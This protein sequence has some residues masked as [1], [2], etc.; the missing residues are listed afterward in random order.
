VAIKVLLPDQVTGPSTD[1]ASRQQRFDREAKAIAALSQPHICAIFDV[2]REDGTAF[3]VM[4]YLEDETLAARL[5][6]GSARSSSSWRAGSQPL[7]SPTPDDGHALPVAETLRIATALADALAAA[8]RAG[9]VHRDLKP[10]NIMLTKS[11]VK[12]LDFGLAKALAADDATAE[13][14]ATMTATTPL[15]GMGTLLGTM[16]YM[17][18]EQVEG[19]EADA[20]SDIFALGAVIYEM[21]T[22]RRA[23]RGASQAS[24]IAAIMDRQPEP[25]SQL[26]P[27]TPMGLERIVSTCLEKD[28]DQRWQHASD[29]AQ[30]RLR[31][32]RP[33]RAP[34]YTYA[35]SQFGHYHE[36]KELMKLIPAYH[37]YLPFVL[38]A[39]PYFGREVDWGT[40][41]RLDQIDLFIE[42]VLFLINQLGWH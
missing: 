40:A 3:L 39:D 9:I 4:E 10:G 19:R 11:G 28:P 37:A 26:Q 32:L 7:A 31:L 2:G 36:S 35:A 38:G 34:P 33:E 18:P 5:A 41:L 16:P 23:F 30:S 20:R 1:S 8:H 21:A 27:L 17:A 24:L 12:V 14:D 29:I 25:I 42:G 6:R 15:T 13:A 22:G